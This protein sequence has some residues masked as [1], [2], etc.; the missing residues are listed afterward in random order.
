MFLT[1]LKDI[2]AIML[3]CITSNLLV[4]KYLKAIGTVIGM[5]LIQIVNKT[6]LIYQ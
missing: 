1:F 2:W 3:E 5:I 4:K 6:N